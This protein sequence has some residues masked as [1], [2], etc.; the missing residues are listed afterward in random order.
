[1]DSV[2]IL[3]CCGGGFS[4]GMLAQKTRK[5]AIKKGINAVVDARS[6]SLVSEYLDAI[7]VLLLGPHYTQQLDHFTN[8]ASNYNVPVAVIP[9]DIYGMMDAERLLQFAF[10]TIEISKEKGE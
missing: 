10:Q 7:D 3:L 2:R 9:N 8:L 6:E 5:E 4:S 1:M